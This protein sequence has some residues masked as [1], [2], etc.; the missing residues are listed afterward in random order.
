MRLFIAVEIDEAFRSAI[1]DVQKQLAEDAIKMV[2]PGNLHITMKFIGEVPDDKAGEIT[3][4][5]KGVKMDPFDM[6]MEEV[7]AFPNMNYIRVLWIG[8]KGPLAELAAKV[9]AALEGLD[10]IQKDRYEFSSHLTIG[11]VKTKPRLLEQ[12]LQGLK[13]PQIGTQKVERFYLVKSTL[14]PGGPVYEHVAEFKLVE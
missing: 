14:G 13:S 8:I 6:K 12:K 4:R 7:G 5:L 11:R 1:A 9:E 2:E 3:G 10:Y